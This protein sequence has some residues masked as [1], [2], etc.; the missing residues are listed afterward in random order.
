[1]RVG[2]AAGVPVLTSPTKWFADLCGV[3]FQPR[4]LTDGVRQLLED[5]G[6]RK[7]LTSGAQLL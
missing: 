5:T 6:L 2:L 4:G 3:T 1:M 7:Q